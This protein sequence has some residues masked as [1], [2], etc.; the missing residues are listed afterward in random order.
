MSETWV[1]TGPHAGSLQVSFR[2]LVR[3]RPH[4]RAAR[5]V[6]LRHAGARA[7]APTA[8]HEPV[9]TCVC[10]QAYAKLL[11]YDPS[12]STVLY[13]LGWI[14][15][16]IPGVDTNAAAAA[17]AATFSVAGTGTSAAPPTLR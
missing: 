15:H 13:K 9:P 4:A 2:T 7:H 10:E 1:L 11:D 17:P 5:R 12:H 16:N 8:R 3:N 6:S 14:Y